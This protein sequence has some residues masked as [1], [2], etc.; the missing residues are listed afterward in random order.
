MMSLSNNGKLYKC[1][2]SMILPTNL[3]NFCCNLIFGFDCSGGA[4]SATATMKVN[5]FAIRKAFVA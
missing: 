4:G 2:Q 3:S 1:T 5:H